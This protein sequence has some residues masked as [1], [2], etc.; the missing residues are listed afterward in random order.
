MPSSTPSSTPSSMPSSG[1]S[2]RSRAALP[3]ILLVALGTPCAAVLACAGLFGP[4]WSAWALQGVLLDECPAGDV[5][6]AAWAR[7]SD[8]GRLDKGTITVGMTGWYADRWNNVQQTAIRRFDT[9]LTAIDPLGKEHRIEQD[10]TASWNFEHTGL[11]VLP[12][13]PD[14]DWTLRVDVDSPAGPSTTELTLPLYAPA[15][16]HVL[17]DSPLYKPGQTIRFR[18]VVLSDKDLSPLED[19]PGSWIVRDSS[20][21]TLLEETTRT[22]PFGVTESTIPI[23]TLAE[24][25]S[26]TVSFRTGANEAARTVPVHPFQLPRFTVETRANKP[27]YGFGDAPRIETTVRYTSGTPVRNAPVDVAFFDQGRPA[28]DGA[29]AWPI[30]ASWLEPQTLSTDAQGKLT[31]TLPAVPGDLVGKGRV[32]VQISARDETGDVAVGS[33]S[34]S[35]TQDKIAVS[36]VTELADGVVPSA[37]NRIFVRATTPDGTPLRNATLALWPS[38]YTRKDATIEKTDADGVARFQ[39]DPGEP[40]TVV[41]PALPW[42]PP[43]LRTTPRLTVNAVTDSLTGVSPQLTTRSLLDRWASR[44]TSCGSLI[45]GAERVNVSVAVLVDGGGRVQRASSG[46]EDPLLAGCAA[47]ALTGQAPADGHDHL[48]RLSLSFEG[49]ETPWLTASSASANGND[50]S[51][52]V[53]AI[54]SSALRRA[55]GCTAGLD[56]NISE[57]GAAWVW[58]TRGGAT[59]I[60]L[61]QVRVETEEGT[62]SAGVQACVARALGGWTLDE[63]AG[64]DGSGTLTVDVN[65]PSP[66]GSD[67]PQPTTWPGYAFQVAAYE[68]DALDAAHEIGVSTLRLHPGTLPDLRLRFS[69]ILVKPGDT[70]QLLAL[71]G[72]NFGSELPKK[73][74]LQSGDRTLQTF[75]FDPKKRTGTVTI[76]LDARGFVHVNWNGARAVAYV[77]DDSAL[78]LTLATDKAQYRPGDVGVLTVTS[79]VGGKPT[80]AG[81][82]LAGVD[83]TLGV[84]APLDGPDGLAGLVVTAD[85]AAPAFG[86]LDARALQTGQIAGHNAAAATILRVT[87]LPPAAPGSTRV[88][89]ESRVVFDANAAVADAFYTFYPEVKTAVRAWEQTATEGQAMTPKIMVGIWN[90]TLS[91]HPTNDPFGRPL[92]LSVLPADLLAFTDPR[93]MV[94]NAA[95]LPEDIE[96]WPTY[97]ASESP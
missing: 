64:S 82:T 15:R 29:P 20:G 97:V 88:S 94:S 58:F 8:V 41:I 86:D 77:L 62:A 69:D 67:K 27:W 61:R 21:E 59:A 12:D 74:V 49:P 51:S 55:R 31:V 9:T 46:G 71:R 17:T 18:A 89:T 4:C 56:D 80:T 32:T 92:R 39:L 14:G 70:L 87:G 66:P 7:V 85:T 13:G 84:L 19:R 34:L 28:D 48:W 43:V 1:R 2:P 52:E 33:A 83:Q 91:A 35:F 16:V 50:S 3:T 37:N 96:N 68:G 90:T 40:I 10:D 60:E 6:P 53:A 81:V 42:R 25:G 93:V 36:A 95:L 75:D 47:S 54:A 79:T 24:S 23:D 57:L 44:A 72:P 38:G 73:M 45:E 5:R 22:G 30:P 76:P 65:F 63:P 78:S 26:W 11:I